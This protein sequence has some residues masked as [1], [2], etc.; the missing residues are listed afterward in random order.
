[1]NK[2]LQKEIEYPSEG[3]YLVDGNDYQVKETGQIRVRTFFAWY[4]VYLGMPDLIPLPG[5]KITWLRNV[6]ITEKQ[7]LYR[8]TDYD[9]GWTYQWFWKSWREKWVIIKLER[10]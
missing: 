2:T 1:M 7:L 10:I 4:P 5:C 6:M 9:S 3:R 8:G